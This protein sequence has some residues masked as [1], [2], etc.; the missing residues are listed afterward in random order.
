LTTQEFV[1]RS[2]VAHGDK[3][4][5]SRSVYTKCHEKV[6]I[7]CPEHGEFK[8]QAGHHMR[9]H[10]CCLCRESRGERKIAEILKRYGV[11]YLREHRFESCRMTYGLPFDFVIRGGKPRIIEFHG[12]QHYYPITFGCRDPKVVHKAFIEVQKRDVF[13]EQWAAKKGLDLLIVPYWEFKRLEEIVGGFL[14]RK[15]IPPS[16]DVPKLVKKYA[17]I[18]D[19]IRRRYA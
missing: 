6:I 9:G 8:Q 13:K 12:E 5:Y 1:N 14:L 10:G 7:V 15:S 2:L 16:E 3:Y 18:R 17:M 4:D 11:S 19:K